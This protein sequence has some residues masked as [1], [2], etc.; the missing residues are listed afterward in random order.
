[1]KWSRRRKE[2][3]RGVGSYHLSIERG[4]ER[5]NVDEAIRLGDVSVHV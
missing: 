2:L 5:E 4:R 3:P 1:M